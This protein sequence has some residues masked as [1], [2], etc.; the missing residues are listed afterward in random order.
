[1][2]LKFEGKTP[3]HF[4]AITGLPWVKWSTSWR[5]LEIPRAHSKV[6]SPH[7][8]PAT[9]FH[10]RL[11][12]LRGDMSRTCTTEMLPMR[13]LSFA[14]WKRDTISK[15][16]DLLMFWKRQGFS[17]HHF[18]GIWAKQYN[19]MWAETIL[20]IKSE[21]NVEDTSDCP[22][23]IDRPRRLCACAASILYHRTFFL[24]L[25]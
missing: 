20:N 21:A 18:Y 22:S 2:F 15:R 13:G 5:C 3:G 24:T 12:K 9:Y 4:S 8:F 23:A 16:R 6:N 17:T 1:M 10:P 11:P 14:C 7:C 25:R 19:G